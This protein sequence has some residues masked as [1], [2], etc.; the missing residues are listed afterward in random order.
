M[1]LVSLVHDDVF[2]LRRAIYSVAPRS[3]PLVKIMPLE[4]ETL[5]GFSENV[6][7][8]CL[9]DGLNHSLD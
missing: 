2:G 1:L 4:V 5:V 6:L 9:I 8:F 3:E 7:V